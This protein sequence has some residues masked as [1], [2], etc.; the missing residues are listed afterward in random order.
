MG[1][2]LGRQVTERALSHRVYPGAFDFDSRPRVHVIDHPGGRDLS[3]SIHDSIWLDTDGTKLH[4][5]T[6]TEPGSSG[7]AVFDRSQSQPACHCNAGEHIG[8]VPAINVM[9]G[10]RLEIG[11][12]PLF[13]SIDYE[14]IAARVS[15]LVLSR[16]AKFE[17]SREEPLQ[18]HEHED[19]T[20]LYR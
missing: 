2:D 18:A 8:Q 15:P 6:P 12:F 19:L 3:F 7:S 9:V 16:R 14:H 5:R 1:F 11:H 20:T 13:S 4:Y 10:A 17:I